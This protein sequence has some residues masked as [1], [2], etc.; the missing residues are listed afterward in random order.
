MNMRNAV[1][2][3]RGFSDWEI[4]D[5]DVIWDG[6]LFHLF[7]LI[8]PNHDYIAHAVSSDGINWSRV[9]NAMYVG[10][11]GEWDDDMLWTMHTHWCDESKRWEMFYTGLR[12]GENG[13]IQRIGKAWS[14]D[15]YY[16]HKEHK[17]PFPL[18]SKGPQY[19]DAQNNPRSWVSFR[20]PFFFTEEGEQYLL[21]AAR[22][23]E[24][25]YSRRGCTGLMQKH[26]DHWLLQ[27]PLHRPLVYDDMECP[28]LVKLEDEYYL[29]ASIREDRKVRYWTSM[30][31]KGAYRS[32]YDNVLMP[33][34]NFA[35]RPVFIDGRLLV[36]TFYF[37]NNDASDKRA[38]VPPRE[39]CRD[40]NG[41]LYLKSYH[42]WDTMRKRTISQSEF[43]EFEPFLD[44]P[45]AITDVDE[46][47]HYFSTSSGYEFFM[48][49]VTEYDFIWDGVLQLDLPGKLG[50]IFHLDE[51]GSGYFL[52][53][54]FFNGFAQ[55][56]AWGV[57][58]DSPFNDYVFQTIQSNQFP[59]NE[60]RKHSFRLISYGHYVELS[61]D[62][63][64]ILSLVDY[65]YDHGKIG[66]YCTSTTVHLSESKINILEPHKEEYGA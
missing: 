50:L 18:E 31:L 43:A 47:I 17:A 48:L 42:G 59:V 32:F 7:H 28:S 44:N 40:K 55:L 2:S 6:K 3:G 5:V 20:D 49:P 36:Y 56:R 8:I 54:D 38:L 21:M 25:H 63:K 41:M 11:P 37:L 15:L 26:G 22:S 34:G 12:M 29:I 33:Q 9:R 4:G 19:E 61:L 39:I 13:S 46:D 60:E 16:W 45:S 62:G 1:Y 65:T 35:A 53:L 51:T 10:E 66:V 57:Q 24:G 64:V 23:G 27:E 52:S 58:E 14:E 30:E